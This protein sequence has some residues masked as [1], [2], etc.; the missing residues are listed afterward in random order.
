MGK[1]GDAEQAVHSTA[2]AAGH[3]SAV[4]RYAATIGGA[5]DAKCVLVL[6]LSIGVFVLVLFMLLPL[7]DHASETIPDDHPGVLPGEIQ[8]SFFLLK[9]RQQ[10]IPHVRRLQKDIYREIGIPNTTVSVSM[11]TSKYKDSTYVKFGILPNPRNS[12]ISA[13]SIIA[14]RKNLIQLTLEQSNLSLTSSVFGDPY[15]LEILG[16]P[17]GITVPPPPDGNI[18]PTA[19]FNVTLNMT[20]QQLRVH[21][22]ELESELRII[23]QLTPYE[24]LIVEITNENGST[25]NLPVTVHI[26]IAPNYPSNYL[27][28]YRLKQLAQ[29]IIKL[30]PKN[31]DLNPIFGMIEN[32]WLSPC[33]QSYIPSCAP[34][35]APAPAPSLS[36]SN[37]EHPQPTTTKPY[38]SFS[39]PALE[40]RKTVSVHR[41]LSTISPM[42]V[43][44][45]IPTRFDSWSVH[46]DRKNRSPLAKPMS[47]VPASPSK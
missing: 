7:H 15:C 2:P 25:I 13:Q 43:P 1:A 5:V 44:P 8:A 46:T 19:L 32:L 37:P 22:K 42:M 33:L 14:L 47:L 31:L 11:H 41:R 36:P 10:L 23:L 6:F 40:R 18:C 34:N 17:G 29:I 20:I 24:D 35:P 28:T 21:L 39:C 30:I 12:S 27:E 4:R 38:G 16:F 3:G 26:L 45:E 9:K